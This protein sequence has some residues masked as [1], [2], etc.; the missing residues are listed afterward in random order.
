MTKNSPPRQRHQQ[1]SSVRSPQNVDGDDLHLVGYGDN[2]RGAL[3]ERAQD[4][5]NLHDRVD[6]RGRQASRLVRVHPAKGQCALN[7]TTGQPLGY[8]PEMVDLTSPAWFME[9]DDDRD[10]RQ[11]HGRSARIR[12]V[13][14][15]RGAANQGTTSA[16]GGVR[17]MT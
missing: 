14:R 11:V 10:L 5:N 3:R 15:A 13:N 4:A 6:A 7:T 1:F 12:G 17:L 8:S 16:Y 9:V 2:A